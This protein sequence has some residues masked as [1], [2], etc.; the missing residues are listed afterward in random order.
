M[1]LHWNQNAHQLKSFDGTDGKSFHLVA[2]L[3]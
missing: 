1:S 3:V 2:L